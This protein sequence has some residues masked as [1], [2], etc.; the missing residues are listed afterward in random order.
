VRAFSI[1]ESTSTSARG[2]ASLQTNNIPGKFAWTSGTIAAGDFVSL[3]TVSSES[4]TGP[5]LSSILITPDD[6]T[7]IAKTMQH[8]RAQTIARQMEVVIVGP[9]RDRIHIRPEDEASF[10]SVTIVEAPDFGSLAVARVAGVAA[11]SAP[12]I[13]FNEDHSFPE[14][15]WAAALLEAH[16]RGYA[17]VA[18]EMKNGNPASALSWAA[19]F[20]HFGG[21][22]EPG[23]GFETEHPAASHNM[24]YTRAALLEMGDGLGELL[25]AESFLHD[26]LR[27]RGHRFWVEPAAATRHVNLSRLRPA[28]VHAWVGGRIYG[29]LRCEFG[30][31]P[32]ARRIVYAGGSPLVPLLKLRRVLTEL[33]RTRSGRNQIPRVLP[34]IAMIL[35]VHAA[36]EAA[37]YLFGVGSSRISYSKLET[38]RERYVRPE[39][40][41]LWA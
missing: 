26:A 3:G 15:G 10:H 41:Q 2:P 32:F 13:A 20:L 4:A 36:G 30:A 5:T 18:P 35:A 34:A 14:A 7:A 21:A 24:S 1:S 22:V 40:R 37:G 33:R 38:R 27:A 8:L 39:E 23:A 25:L 12:V 31:W 28:I 19:I 29:G 6:Y 16:R 17:G 11:A 9:R